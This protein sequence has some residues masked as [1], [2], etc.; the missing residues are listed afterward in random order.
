MPHITTLQ[1]QKDLNYDE[2]V[3]LTHGNS[4]PTRPQKVQCQ[5]SA[6]THVH[7]NCVFSFN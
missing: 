5:Q 2:R 6:I 7:F 1:K 4:Y 3:E